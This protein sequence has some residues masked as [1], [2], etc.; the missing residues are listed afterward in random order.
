[1]DI[2]AGG[3][4]EMSLYANFTLQRFVF[5]IFF[6]H[7]TQM[8]ERPEQICAFRHRK[9]VTETHRLGKKFMLLTWQEA[10]NI[11]GAKFWIDNN[12]HQVAE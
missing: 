10:E 6:L 3:H 12:K 11:I 1:M 7:S 5:N 4:R 8:N 9:V 2:D